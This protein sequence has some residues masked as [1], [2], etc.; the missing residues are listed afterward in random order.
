MQNKST[1]S[2]DITIQAFQSGVF[3]HCNGSISS[4]PS[5]VG[6]TFT[7]LY[8]GETITSQTIL[9]YLMDDRSV[10]RHSFALGSSCFLDQVVL[11]IWFSI[12]FNNPKL[13]RWLEIFI[14][15]LARDIFRQSMVG[16][17]L[18]YNTL[19]IFRMSDPVLNFFKLV[20]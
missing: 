11:A 10:L 20:L 15:V 18:Y 12:F 5:Q 16:I 2:L 14:K 8:L 9:I 13:N 17:K 3:N 4:I 1:R 19:K 7:Y 6:L